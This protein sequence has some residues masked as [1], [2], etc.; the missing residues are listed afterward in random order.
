MKLL[1]RELYRKP[2]SA[3]FSIPAESEQ[4]VH[5]LCMKDGAVPPRYCRVSWRHF[6]YGIS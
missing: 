4:C 3:P 2:V 5:V 6:C 1:L